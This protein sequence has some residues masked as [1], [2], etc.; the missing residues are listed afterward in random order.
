ME[1]NKFDIMQL[2]L[3]NTILSEDVYANEVVPILRVVYN[4][5][6][7]EVISQCY[8]DIYKIYEKCKR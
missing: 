7:V 1:I 3:D 6:D 8:Y 2:I 4:T 5:K